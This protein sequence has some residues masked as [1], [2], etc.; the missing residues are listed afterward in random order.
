[1]I[2]IILKA[3]ITLLFFATT[4]AKAQK[5][6]GK[7]LYQTKFIMSDATKKRMDSSKMPNDRKAFMMKMMKKRMEKVYVLDFN[8]SASIF[9]E[10]KTLAA[11]DESSRFSRSSDNVLYKNTKE[12]HFTNKK[13]TLGKIFLIKDSL[14]SY[15]WTLEKES[16][17]IG[18]HLCFKATAEKEV[19]SDLNRFSRFMNKKKESEK[20]SSKVK[21]FKKIKI[22]AWYTPEIPVAHG[23]RE[24]HGL[25]GLILEVDMSNFQLLCTK[26][27]LNPKE[28]EAI[29]AP[30]KGKEI[31]QK[32][33]DKMMED[34]MKEM[35]ERF[36][37]GRK[38]GSDSRKGHRF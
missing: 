13:E 32:K 30:T 31:S 16:K 22:T 35:R 29:E 20:D 5:F 10:E 36:K 24:F 1:M 6:Q 12:H 18:K 8:K 7:A 33:Y 9:K 27:V 34:K 15:N 14:P 4:I 19:K 37:S 28:K 21:T 2:R 17:M 3:I 23:P 25:P 38:K 11:P 26:I